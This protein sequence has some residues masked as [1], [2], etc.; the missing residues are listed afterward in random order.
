MNVVIHHCLLIGVL[1][2]HKFPMLHFIMHINSISRG[3]ET[4]M[5]FNIYVC[6]MQVFLII[7][8]F[9]KYDFIVIWWT[10]QFIVLAVV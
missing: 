3:T 2:T 5:N 6:I 1:H 8:K 9:E 4:F 10:F 7:C